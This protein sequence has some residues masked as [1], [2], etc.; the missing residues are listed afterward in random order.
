[1]SKVVVTVF[2]LVVMAQTL[3]AQPVEVRRA[4]VPSVA[5]KTQI[6]GVD[7]Q[8]HAESESEDNFFSQETKESSEL[9]LETAVDEVLS[10]V[11]RGLRSRLKRVWKK[12]IRPAVKKAVVAHAVKT[13]VPVAVAALG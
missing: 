2:C 5:F 9:V 1:M 12:H 4:L 3:L 7:V 13:V 10:R 6:P 8:S 11:R